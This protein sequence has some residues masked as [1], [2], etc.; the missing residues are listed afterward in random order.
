MTQK[1]PK[2]NYIRLSAKYKLEHQK[3]QT[4]ISRVALMRITVFLAGLAALY[5]STFYTSLHVV[6]V[7]AVF[8]TGFVLIVV[9]HARLHQR[10]D[11]NARLLLINENEI[12]ALDGDYSNFAE[13]E[14]YS[15]PDH[16]FSGDLD[17]FGRGSIFQY[18]NRSATVIGEKTLARWFNNPTKK[19]DE[20]KKRQEAI[21]DLKDRIEWRQQFQSVGLWLQD[22]EEDR[23]GILEW[24]TR[25][26]EFHQGIYRILLVLIPLLS[27]FMLV[28]MLMGN[29]SFQSFVLYLLVPLGIAIGRSKTVNRNHA[30]LSKKADLLEKYGRLIHLI[31][32]EKFKSKTLREAQAELTGVHKS[33]DALRRLA[34]IIQAFDSRLN[35]FAWVILNAF[36]LW[37][38]RQ[39]RRLEYWR[40]I[41]KN[42]V[43]A[44]FEIMALF[45]ALSSLACFWHNHPAF[46]LPKPVEKNF[47]LEAKNCGHPL[48]KAESRVDNP[49]SFEGWHNFIIVTGAN[50]AGK[51]TYLR[52]VAVN[53]ILA[54]TGAPVCASSFVYS[55]ADIFTS[56]RTRDNLLQNESYFFAELKRLKAIIDTLQSGAQLFI[57]LDEILKGTNSKDK[58]EGSKALLQQLIRYD[59]SGLIATHDLK[60]GELIDAYPSNIRNMRFEVEIKNDA[61]VFDYQL[62]TGISQNL[63]ATF[64]MKKMGITI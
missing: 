14:A 36:I 30:L 64:L 45:D 57:I 16:P 28:M 59:A 38:I 5:F 60:L 63:N 32:T 34:K 31:E 12:K 1:S 39:A 3:L 26:A 62:K 15:H 48:L 46:V 33:G 17:I 47:V 42:D 18:L 21:S 6:I 35:I 51:S 29:V 52:T 37:D 2:Q 55:P 8:V 58:Q 43:E 56:I 54:M 24:M 22:K 19:I 20:I 23:K 10:R 7:A 44:W 49:I 25:P 61:L 9:W 11:E 27:T 50:M 4:M 13:G 41:H 40:E 53:F